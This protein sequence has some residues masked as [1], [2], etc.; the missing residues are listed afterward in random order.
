MVG[1]FASSS[2]PL[3][4]HAPLGLPELPIVLQNLAFL[5]DPLDLV[6]D[7]GANKHC[8]KQPMSVHGR[9]SSGNGTVDRTLFPDQAVVS[10]IGV[11]GI[12]S[13]RTT[14]VADYP[15]V[16]LCIAQHGQ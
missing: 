1:H 5:D 2:L 12:A 14:A 13:G 15:K 3:V 16:E 6:D 10:V 4:S 11:I 8:H 9:F 7:E